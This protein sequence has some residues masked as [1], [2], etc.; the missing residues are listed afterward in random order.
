MMTSLP[1]SQNGKYSPLNSKNS[2]GLVGVGGCLKGSD[3]ENSKGVFRNRIQLIL[4]ACPVLVT[5][6]VG[7][8]GDHVNSHG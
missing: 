3:G 4:H 8:A 1:C 5:S 2:E 6:E 7:R